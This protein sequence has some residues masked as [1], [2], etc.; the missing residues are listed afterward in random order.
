MDT[1]IEEIAAF[2]ARHG[3]SESQFGVLAL[4]DKNLVPDLRKGRDLRFSTMDRI[5]KCMADRPQDR[6]A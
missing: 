3:M 6:A 5:R 1:L 2:C 4:N